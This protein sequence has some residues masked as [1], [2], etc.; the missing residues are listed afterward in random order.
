MHSKVQRTLLA[1]DALVASLCWWTCFG[2]LLCTLPLFLLVSF[3]DA[4]Q[5]CWQ[6]IDAFNSG[7]NSGFVCMSGQVVCHVA[8]DFQAVQF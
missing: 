5:R 6:P 1:D 8:H 4:Q 7:V 3:Q 2:M